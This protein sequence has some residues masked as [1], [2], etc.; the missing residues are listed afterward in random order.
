MKFTEARLE[1]AIIELLGM[2]LM[3]LRDKPIQD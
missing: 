1:Q 3:I 2:A